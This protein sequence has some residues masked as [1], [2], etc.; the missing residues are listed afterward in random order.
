MGNMDIGLSGLRVALTALDTVGNN[1]ANAATEGYH[2]QEI[3]VSPIPSG[4]GT[5]HPTGAGAEVTDIRR[6]VDA[7]TEKEILRQQPLQGQTAQE[8][9]T[10]Q[11]VETI[12]G[13][14]STGGLSQALDAFF[15]SL[16]EVAG[17][18]QSAALR[19]QVVWAADAL[20][21]KFRGISSG[22]NEIDAALRREADNLIDQVNGLATEIADLNRRIRDL[23]VRG[24]PDNNLIDRRDQ[25]VVRVSELLDVEI[26]QGDD[27]TVSL[28]AGGRTVVVRTQATALEVGTT[29][30]GKLGISVAGAGNFDEQAG[31]GRLG[32]ILT[33]END[34]LPQT[35][36]A[37]DALATEIIR[38]INQAH[39]Q[40]VG[41]AG[42]FTQ[43]IGNVT[44]DDLSAWQ[45]PPAAGQVFVRITNTATGAVE[46]KAVTVDPGSADPAVS[47]LSG[48]A[49]Q[50]DALAG[51]GASVTAAGLRLAADTG[52]QF[53]FLPAVLPAP[54]TSGLTPGSAQ[55]TFSGNYTGTANQ[56]FT[57]RIVGTGAVGVTDGLAVEVADGGGNVV[58]NLSVGRGYAAGDVL[59]AADGIRLNLSSGNLTDGETFTADAIASS[60]TSGFLAGAGINVFFH[61]ASAAT[62]DVADDL[63]TSSRRLATASGAGG[64]DNL[65]ALRMAGLADARFERLDGATISGRYRQ[66]AA[67]VGLKIATRQALQEA[68]ERA[69][70][71]LANQRDKLSGVDLNEEAAKM[72]LFEQLFQSMAKYLATV[73]QTQQALFTVVVSQ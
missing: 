55:P 35:L 30:D 69:L 1:M 4:L 11:S 20:S 56:T 64:A 58:A 24:T 73:N 57:F 63:R 27:G 48:I 72:L 5:G 70:T 8:L 18:P 39:V 61:G 25:A 52:Y 15:A 28:F 71:Q 59:E 16:R 34:I 19:D 37:L 14:M 43:T 26:Q 44:E 31:G 10:L 3:R 22:I 51:L 45:P 9:E 67:N 33:L 60:D 2:R 53:D 46:R 7:I 23:Y 12:L 17:Q 38:S 65:N 66:L 29:P 62:I 42:S 47:T 21:A 49:S 6:L 36:G 68:S 13:D 50:F 54:T 40:G 32:G 41:A